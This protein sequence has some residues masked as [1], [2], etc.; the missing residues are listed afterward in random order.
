MRAMLGFFARVSSGASGSAG[1]GK[2]DQDCT[3]DA[4][5]AAPSGLNER[6]AYAGPANTG[7]SAGSCGNP[8]AI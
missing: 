3:R 4:G 8:S 1:H 6:R 5:H 7:P 2:R